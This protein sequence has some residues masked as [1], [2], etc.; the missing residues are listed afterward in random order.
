MR[1]FVWLFVSLAF[2]VAVPGF[3]QT[4]DAADEASFGYLPLSRILPVVGSTAGAAGSFFKT[5]IQVFNPSPSPIPGRFVF[6]ASG[7]PGSPTDPSMDFTVG[8][9]QTIQWG[10]VL[11]A[12]GLSGL[13]TLDIML[14]SASA[15]PAIIV[16][17][18]FNDAE[19][20]GTSGFTEESVNVSDVGPGGLVITNAQT[21]YLVL[22]ADLERFRFNIGIRT[23]ASTST[24]QFTVFDAL[25]NVVGNASKSVGPSSFLQ[26]E[27]GA[28]L[29]IALPPSGSIR[30][31]VSGAG[32]IVYGATTD[33]I[34]ND[35]SIQYARA[36]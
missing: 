21:G 15:S 6:H 3:A 10:D 20:A 2:A 8:P 31:R 32:S 25:G 1:R 28:M 11:P 12:M 17:R 18:V 23:L 24:L 22:P 7:A 30:V 13:G 33:N 36:L 35:P 16:S 9:Q 5:A 34:T 27:A 4:L 14:P 26:Q 29:G 19:Q